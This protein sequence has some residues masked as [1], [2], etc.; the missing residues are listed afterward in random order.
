MSFFWAVT[1][2]ISAQ[3][4]VNSYII[5]AGSF[6][7]FRCKW[8]FT[9]INEKRISVGINVREFFSNNG[10]NTAIVLRLPEN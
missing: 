9:I 3:L 8:C 6:E 5:I 1:C 2:T 4:Q 10:A 7:E